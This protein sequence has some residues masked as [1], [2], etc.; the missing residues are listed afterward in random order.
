MNRRRKVIGL[1]GELQ[2]GRGARRDI[3]VVYIRAQTALYRYILL[4]TAYNTAK[5]TVLGG[6]I[7]N[8]Y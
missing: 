4:Y 3:L 8:K 7:I 1:V 2:R 6:G 5:Y